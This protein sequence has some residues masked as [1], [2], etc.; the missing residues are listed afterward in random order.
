MV[1]LVT[2]GFEFVA[3]V[4]VFVFVDYDTLLVFLMIDGFI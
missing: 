2:D 3:V 1:F 4:V